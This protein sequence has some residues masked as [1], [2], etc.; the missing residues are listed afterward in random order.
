MSRIGKQPIPIPSGVAVTI[1]GATITVVGPKGRLVRE[2]HPMVR[3]ARE[4]EVLSVAIQDTKA[5]DQRALWGLSA[6]LLANMIEGVTKGFTKQLELVG[7]GFKASVSGQAM[8]LSLGFSHQ[9]V[10]PLPQGVSATVEKN[11]LITIVGMNNEEVGNTAAAIRALRKP[12]P[13]QGKGIKY[14]GEVIR[15]K[16]GKAAKAAGAGA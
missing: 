3:I 12:E 7:V 5:K 15:R 8:T 2:F 4:G 10:F 14:V 13:Y 16:L 1:N 9:I 11:T 6:R